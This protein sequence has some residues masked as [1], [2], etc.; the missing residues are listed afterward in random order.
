M[1]LTLR[2]VAGLT[3]AEIA[4]AFLQDEPQVVRRIAGAKQTLAEEGVGFTRPSEAAMP[5]RLASVLEVVYLVLNEGYAATAGQDLIRA[6]LCREAL[7][8]G[9]MLATRLG[10]DLQASHQEQEA[11]SQG[12]GP[13]DG[14]DSLRRGDAGR[15]A[16]HH[17]MGQVERCERHGRRVGPGA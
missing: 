5:G 9:R 2:L 16:G 14:S 6:D 17:R 1:A 3:A 10:S 8:L 4:R 13:H 7:R 12:S 11:R 15:P